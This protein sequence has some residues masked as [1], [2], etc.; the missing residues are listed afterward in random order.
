MITRPEY[1]ERSP[2]GERWPGT[3]G[4]LIAAMED[5]TL[6]SLQD[7]R[8]FTLMSVRNGHAEPFRTYWNGMWST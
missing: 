7:G 2:D 8:E 5:T 6:K 1:Y 4:G 3:L